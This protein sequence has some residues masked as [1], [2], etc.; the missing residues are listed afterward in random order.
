MTICK[1]SF[2]KKATGEFISKAGWFSAAHVQRWR[3]C[4]IWRG[5]RRASFLHTILALQWSV[6]LN[7][8][9]TCLPPS[10]QK[11]IAQLSLPLFSVSSTYIFKVFFFSWERCCLTET[12]IWL[13][14]PWSAQKKLNLNILNIHNRSRTANQLPLIVL[15]NTDT[16]S[17]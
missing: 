9:L 16:W 2:P 15:S 3:L 17:V 13:R 6:T 14:S 10:V 4:N 1:L 11:Q 5:R 7:L 12:V 8:C